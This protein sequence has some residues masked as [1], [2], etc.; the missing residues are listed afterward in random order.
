MPRTLPLKKKG[1]SL[2][3]REASTKYRKFLRDHP[4]ANITEYNKALEKFTQDCEEWEYN[5]K[6]YLS[7]LDTDE[8]P[9]KQ[10]GD[11]DDLEEVDQSDEDL[12]RAV[13][14]LRY[15]RTVSRRGWRLKRL[16][17]SLRALRVRRRFWC[18]R[19]LGR[20]WIGFLLFT[21]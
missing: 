8:L 5:Y 13:G 4:N 3:A 16:W 12:V 15:S 17:R 21:C 2:K 10:E 20:R 9:L 19:I 7:S 11:G 1:Q 18:L 6:E 14:Q